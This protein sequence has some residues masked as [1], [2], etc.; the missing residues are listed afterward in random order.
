MNKFHNPIY[1]IKQ[2]NKKFQNF[3][4][5]VHLTYLKQTEK[6]KFD[7]FLTLKIMS[8]KLITRYTLLF[9]YHYDY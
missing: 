4:F 5:Q 2:F 8:K 6:L 1:I 3:V 7:F 9:E